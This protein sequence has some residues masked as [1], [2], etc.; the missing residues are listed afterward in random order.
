MP[1]GLLDISYRAP[2]QTVPVLVN[3]RDPRELDDFCADTRPVV[4][5]SLNAAGFL[6]FGRA[7]ECLHGD[8]FQGRLVIAPKHEAIRDALEAPR[9][10]SGVLFLQRSGWKARLFAELSW[11]PW[12]GNEGPSYLPPK[13][14]SERAVLTAF[15]TWHQAVGGVGDIL[16]IDGMSY[17]EQ[18]ELVDPADLD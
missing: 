5:F 10:V 11:D 17:E 12:R 15:N 6:W 1:Y 4:R 18:V 13:N 2:G 3:P 7:M 8:E 16:W 9:L 14:L